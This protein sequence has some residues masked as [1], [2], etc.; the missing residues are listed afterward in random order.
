[1]G[2]VL[3]IWANYL[4]SLINQNSARHLLIP[5]PIAS[6]LPITRQTSMNSQFNK[7]AARILKAVIEFFYFIHALKRS[8]M[9]ISHKMDNRGFSRW[10]KNFW[11]LQIFIFKMVS[12]VI[13]HRFIFWVIK[14][15]QKSAYLCQPFK[16]FIFAISYYFF[17]KFLDTWPTI[18][19]QIDK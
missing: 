16:G 19:S 11:V 9:K 10:W 14:R 13:E 12:H 7:A 18:W 6:N 5:I 4:F 3:W 15:I 1:M 17:E 2:E 8:I